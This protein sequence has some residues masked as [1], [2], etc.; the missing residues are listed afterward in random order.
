[1]SQFF[2]FVLSGVALLL[3]IVMD[4]QTKI[5]VDARLKVNM[6]GGLPV[7]PRLGR[8]PAFDERRSTV[9]RDGWRKTRDGPPVARHQAPSGLVQQA[10]NGHTPS[11]VALG[12]AY[13]QGS[14]V[15]ADPRQAAHWFREAARRGDPMGIFN[16]GVMFEH[17]GGV[18]QDIGM[19]IRLFEEAARRGYPNAQRK[20][21]AYRFR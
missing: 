19:A 8:P 20:L 10:Q 14:G 16:L 9:P 18:P 1:M 6:E 17:G 3:F 4:D 12:I 2:G 15:P 21:D 5:S 7:G 13:L 11:Q